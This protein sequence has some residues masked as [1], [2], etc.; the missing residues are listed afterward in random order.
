M[1]DITGFRF[2]YS[3]KNNNYLD[4]RNAIMAVKK[5]ALSK[6]IIRTLSHVNNLSP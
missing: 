2:K 3:D 1:L 5:N 4:S 6:T